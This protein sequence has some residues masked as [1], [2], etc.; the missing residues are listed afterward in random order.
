M[1]ASPLRPLCGPGRR[2]L[3]TRSQSW[4]LLQPSGRG[5]ERGGWREEGENRSWCIII[6]L[7]HM[8]MGMCS[9]YSI[10]HMGTPLQ[11]TWVS[12]S[13]CGYSLTAHVGLLQHMWAL[14]Y[15]TCADIILVC[16][17]H[18]SLLTAL[19]QLL[20]TC[21]SSSGFLMQEP[22]NI[23]TTNTAEVVTM[24]IRITSNIL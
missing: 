2:N 3:L 14:P 5:R 15:S 13:T 10:T 12:Y 21:M 17:Q 16:I 24:A 19:V 1:Y 11:H 4:C 6:P 9:K 23:A 22:S 18:Y 20:L 7:Q 8:S